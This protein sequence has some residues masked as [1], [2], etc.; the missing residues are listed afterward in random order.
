MPKT[1]RSARVSADNGARVAANSA[2]HTATMHAKARKEKQPVPEWQRI[3]TLALGDLIVFLIFATIGRRSH[4][5]AAS[6]SNLWQIFLTAL[7]FAVGWFLVSPFVGAYRRF[8]M[9]SPRK[10]AQRTILAW[11]LSWPVAMA[12]RGI[13]V[14]HAIP[15]ATFAVI[16]LLTNLVLLLVWR[17]PYA[18]TNSLR[19]RK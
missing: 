14:D 3:S 4:G 18:Y 8:L 7:P 15:P 16:T 6:L 9:S 2:A 1:K 13:F 10:M 11:I 12:L 5:E 17:W 19:N